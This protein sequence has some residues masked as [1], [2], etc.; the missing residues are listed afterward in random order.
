MV[1]TLFRCIVEGCT[2]QKALDG[3]SRRQDL[4]IHIDRTHKKIRGQHKCPLCSRQFDTRRGLNKHL[5]IKHNGECKGKD[6]KFKCSECSMRFNTKKE[7]VDHDC[8]FQCSKCLCIFKD[9]KEFNLHVLNSS[10][11]NKE[12]KKRAKD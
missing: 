4:L 6:F 2:H 12:S 11:Y 7:L 5:V 8:N 10:C 9:K 3:Y 1:K